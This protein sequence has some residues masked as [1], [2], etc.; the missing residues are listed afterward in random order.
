MLVRYVSVEKGEF[1]AV[2]RG[3]LNDWK[4]YMHNVV[5]IKTLKGR[6]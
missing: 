2:Y 6:V 4:N 1:G 5:A 3:T